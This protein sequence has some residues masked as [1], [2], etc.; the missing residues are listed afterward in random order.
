MQNETNSLSTIGPFI[1]S[2]IQDFKQMRNDNHF[3]NQFQLQVEEIIAKIPPNKR[4]RKRN[5]QPEFAYMFQD[6]IEEDNE[7]CLIDYYKINF[8]IFVFSIY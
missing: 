3:K 5:E 6:N 1:Y 4:K 2:L 8:Y 7:L